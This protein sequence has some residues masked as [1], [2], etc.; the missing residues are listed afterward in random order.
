MFARPANR[1]NNLPERERGTD[2][3]GK[4]IPRVTA[5]GLF[6]YNIGAWRRDA[7]KSEVPWDVSTEAEVSKPIVTY[8]RKFDEIMGEAGANELAA[9]RGVRLWQKAPGEFK[10]YKARAKKNGGD[11]EASWQAVPEKYRKKVDHQLKKDGIV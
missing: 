1:F 5:W 4:K 7:A 9:L 11:F 6:Q 10:K 3:K 8:A 2:A